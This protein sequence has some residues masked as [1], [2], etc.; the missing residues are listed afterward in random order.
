MSV[1]TDPQANQPTP[2][3]TVGEVT[4]TTESFVNKLVETKGQNFLDPE[5][6]AKSKLEA[7]AFIANLE[8]QNSQLREDLSKQDYSKDLL[9][10]LQ[11][12]KAAEIA[13]VPAGESNNNNGNT[14][15]DDGTKSL[16]GGDLDSLITEALAK[17]D[18]D[19][20][21]SSNLEL[22]DKKLDELYG[23]EA[24]KTIEAKGNELGLSKERLQE[25]AAESPAAFFTLIGETAV[26]VDNPVTASTVNTAGAYNHTADRDY[27]HYSKIRRENPSLYYSPKV[28]REMVSDAERIGSKFY[29]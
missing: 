7:D 23:T 5:V 8:Q 15:P 9:T 26:K 21:T 18:L 12:N 6:V 24:A 2:T 3:E 1:F 22:V 14:I 29:S 4:P 11:Q 27:N 25:M 19:S 17:R 10:Q 20:K 16:G 13:P 28:Q